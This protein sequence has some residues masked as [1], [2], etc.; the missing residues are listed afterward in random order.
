MCNKCLSFVMALALALT[1]GV[2]AASVWTVPG[3]FPDLKTA[4]H[5][6]KADDTL[7]VLPGHYSGCQWTDMFYEFKPVRIIGRDGPEATILDGRNE[8]IGMHFRNLPDYRMIFEGF[9]ITNCVGERIGGVNFH[10]NASVIFRK[11][12][13]Q[14]GRATEQNLPVPGEGG[15]MRVWGANPIIEDVLIQNC[16]AQQG[17]GINIL[18]SS[19]PIFRR[20]R[21]ENCS[22]SAVMSSEY[23][24]LLF[25]DC[26]FINNAG[27]TWGHTAGVGVYIGCTGQ[28]TRC[29]IQGNNN[30]FDNSSGL[31]IGGSN[32]TF[33]Q[34]MIVDNTAVGH[35]AGIIAHNSADVVMNYCTIAGN[36]ARGKGD[37]AAAMGNSSI[38]FNNCIIWQP[39][40][41]FY[42]ES[43]GTFA[44]TNNDVSMDLPD[45]D[46]FS[47]N[48]MFVGDGDYHLICGSPCRDRGRDM[49]E[50]IDIDMDWVE[51]PN[52][53]WD[54]GAD[55]IFTSIPGDITVTIEM[56]SNLF[57]PGN[58]CYLDVL[59]E[60]FGSGICRAMLIL[61]LDV[62]GEIYFWPTWDTYF[63]KDFIEI[64]SKPSRISILPD[65]IW[66]DN[67]GTAMGLFFHTGVLDTTMTQIL[68]NIESFCFGFSQ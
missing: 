62:Y 61:V 37:G 32:V 40:G 57:L 35:G 66:P 17:G 5:E 39:G 41:E 52:E 60:N 24:T 65:F 20:V 51:D 38:T 28:F 9:T 21:I 67:A 7:I 58:N 27:S 47:V 30:T 4:Y 45:T 22:G 14:N 6:A 44:C 55:E 16:H 23:N 2:A 56:P 48:P 49:G 18:C 34:C 10:E 11:N 33:D 1:G 63:D 68:S 8:V 43:G 19:R 3:D 12:I 42:M 50:R 53:K 59:T 29:L 36:S 54:V 15:G 13:I 26:E 25:E 31:Y 46:N 64:P